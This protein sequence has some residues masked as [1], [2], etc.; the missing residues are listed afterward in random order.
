MLQWLPIHAIMMHHTCRV[1]IQTKIMSPSIMTPQVPLS[2]YTSKYYN[3]M[4]K[5]AAHIHMLSIY[6]LWFKLARMHYTWLWQLVELSWAMIH[7]KPLSC[8]TIVPSTKDEISKAHQWSHFDK[9]KIRNACC[10]VLTSKEC[11][12]IMLQGER[13]PKGLL[14]VQPNSYWNNW[15]GSSWLHFTLCWCSSQFHSHQADLCFISV[16]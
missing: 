4:Y 10:Q 15:N 11:R 16:V 3:F 6:S 2:S 8:P 5:H 7:A 14:R 13:Y 12:Y 1:H 9:T